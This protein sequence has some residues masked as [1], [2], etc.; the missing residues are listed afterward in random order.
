MVFP[1]AR[2]VSERGHG[3]PDGFPVQLELKTERFGMAF[4]LQFAYAFVC[5]ESEQNSSHPRLYCSEPVEKLPNFQ[6][7]PR[8]VLRLLLRGAGNRPCF[9][10]GL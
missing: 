1:F 10:S 5:P 7:S 2:R 9:A 8:E 4:R 6:S 3:H